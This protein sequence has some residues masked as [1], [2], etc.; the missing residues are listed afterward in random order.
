MS[1]VQLASLN[2]L[3]LRVLTTYL[4]CNNAGCRTAP[5]TPV[6]SIIKPKTSNSR[7]IVVLPN[8][9]SGVSNIPSCYQTLAKLG[10]N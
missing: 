9:A 3:G 2:G 7:G 5:D 10:L 1:K 8:C 6:L 4:L